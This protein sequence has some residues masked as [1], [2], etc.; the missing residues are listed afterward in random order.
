MH[1]LNEAIHARPH[2]TTD[3]SCADA[4]ESRET[5]DR[6]GVRSLSDRDDDEE[7]DDG[8]SSEEDDGK[9]SA[10]A[11]SSS[12]DLRDEEDEDDDGARARVRER[13]VDAREGF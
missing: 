10:R 5:E 12:S 2:S 7:E 8:T 4:G 1:A 3:C 6:R 9:F 11:A 13:G